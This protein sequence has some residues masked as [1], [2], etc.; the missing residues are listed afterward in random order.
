MLRLPVKNGI[1]N[2]SNWTRSKSSSNAIRKTFIE[3]FKDNH[4]HKHVKSSSVVPLYDS[5]VPFVNAGMNQFKGVL[6]GKVDPPC[7]RAVNS[8]KCIRVGGKHNDLDVVGTDGTHHTFFEMLGNWSFGDYYKKEACQMAWDLLL[9]PYRLKPDNLVVTY[10]SGDAIMGL[11][12]DRECRDIWK[13]IGVPSSQIRGLSATDNFWEM[14]TT[15]PC[16]PCTEIHYVNPDGSLTEIWN[17]V[18]IQ[19]NRE[20]DGSVKGL[21]RFHVDTGMGLERIVA[22]LQDVKSNYDT[23]L[24]KPI[25]TAIE[26]QGRGSIQRKV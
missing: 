9:G 1:G 14:G 25:I 19:C 11:Q 6:L 2:K 23:D 16:G 24:F 26:K 13:A 4:G 3:Y 22:L 21:K 20:A 17:L 12:E 5:T 18:F 15:G 10:F 8:Q 7:P